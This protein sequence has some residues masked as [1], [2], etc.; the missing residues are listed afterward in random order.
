MIILDLYKT[1][2]AKFVV[3]TRVFAEMVEISTMD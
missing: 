2:A 3:N 1:T